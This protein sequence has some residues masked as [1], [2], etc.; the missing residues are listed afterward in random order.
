MERKTVAE[1]AQEIIELRRKSF[2]LPSDILDHKSYAPVLDSKRCNLNALGDFASLL[3]LLPFIFYNKETREVDQIGDQKYLYG[4][5]PF[6]EYMADLFEKK[7]K[8]SNLAQNT[9][10]KRAKLAPSTI[11]M[12]FSGKRTCTTLTLE[13]MAD[14]VNLFPVYLVPKNSGA[15]PPDLY[16]ENVGELIGL[17]RRYVLLPDSEVSAEN[18]RQSIEYGERIG[19]WTEALR[20]KY[21]TFQSNK[22]K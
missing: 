12:I 3:G 14:V 21:R 13:K 19:E 4:I 16:K 10:G 5:M 1:K 22:K 11:S 7:L 15:P 20:L 8:E 2:D 17:F 6:Q 9:L 18:L